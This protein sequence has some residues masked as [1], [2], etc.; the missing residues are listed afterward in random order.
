MSL[1]ADVYHTRKHHDLGGSGIEIIQMEAHKS[2]AG[3]QSLNNLPTNQWT[4]YV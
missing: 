2:G 3:G 1:T 4:T